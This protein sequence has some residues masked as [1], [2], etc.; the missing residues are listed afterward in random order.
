MQP[1]L[2]YTTKAGILRIMLQFANEKEMQN[3]EAVLA[4]LWC[5]FGHENY[6][7]KEIFVRDL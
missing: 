1:K 3:R 2:E 7:A 5:I 6:Q 4:V